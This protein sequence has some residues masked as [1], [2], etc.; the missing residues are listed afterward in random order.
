MKKFQSVSTTT[1][2]ASLAVLGILGFGARNLDAQQRGEFSSK[3]LT[4][5]YVLAESGTVGSASGLAA[6]GRLTFDGN[7]G[8]SG[9]EL[10]RNSNRNVTTTCTGTYAIE[11]DGRGT[12]IL[13]HTEPTPVAEGEEASTTQSA[14][15]FVVHGAGSVGD[16]LSAIRS[17]N[18][19]AVTVHLTRAQV[20]A[21]VSS[22][23]GAYV[24]SE[25][26]TAGSAGETTLAGLGLVN[27]DGMGGVSGW[28][29]VRFAGGSL[30]TKFVGTYSID[31][32]GVGTMN[33]IHTLPGPVAEGE[34]PKTATSSYKFLVDVDGIKELHAVRTENGIAVSSTFTSR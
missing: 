32:G 12:L 6:I 29:T 33:I 3:T 18:G 23:K 19:T 4:G 15:E 20:G 27:L 31:A 25:R 14:Y 11:P 2:I 16:S 24:L 30:T 13:T 28:E 34:E 17:D 21:S 5:D 8:V 10:V 22:L 1:L 9:W 7:G 26:G